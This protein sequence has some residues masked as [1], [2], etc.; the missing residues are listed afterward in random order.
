MATR[1][2]Y[3]DYGTCRAIFRRAY[4]TSMLWFMGRAVAAAAA[5]D[6][7]VRREFDTL[8]VAFTFALGVWPQ[9][10][11]MVVAKGPDGRVR[12]RGGR[13]AGVE[14]DLLMQI[15]HLETAF[16]MFTFRESTAT[17]FARD[18]LLVEGDVAYAVPVARVLDLTQVYLLPRLIARLAVKRIPRWKPWRTWIGRL[19][20]Y[21]RT[22][23]GY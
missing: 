20:I 13:T 7:D 6:P 11:A 5:V 23:W 19:R 9:G 12:Y 10:P 21:W 8:P 22:L 17:A 14:L 3:R 1:W 16:Q 18:R 4:L 15:K 2:E